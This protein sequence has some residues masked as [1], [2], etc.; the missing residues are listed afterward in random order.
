ME[1]LAKIYKGTVTEQQSA[2]LHYFYSTD[3]ETKFNVKASAMKA[4]YPEARAER[5][6]TALIKKMGYTGAKYSL[7][8]I[9]ITKPYLATK[10]KEIMDSAKPKDQIPAIR[11]SWGL[12]GETTDGE[13]S[14]GNTFNAP[15]MIIQGMTQSRMKALRE[16][17]PQLSDEKMEA[18][19]NERVAGRLEAFKRGELGFTVRHSRAEHET[20]IP[21]LDDDD[22]ESPDEAPSG[23]G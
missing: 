2:F 20:E 22:A 5:I 9:G 17:I 6:G 15:V 8:A 3:S 10:L 14:K 23:A 19:E 21:N 4:G 18:E 16:A 13:E 1:R 11:M 7:E 12:L